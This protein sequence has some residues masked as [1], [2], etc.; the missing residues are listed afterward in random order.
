MAAILAAIVVLG[1][2]AAAAADEPAVRSVALDDRPRHWVGNTC[3]V[4][5]VALIVASFQIHER[6]N[7]HFDDYLEATDPDEI[8][9]HYDQTV[10]LDRWS[11][12][13]LI[14]GQVMIAGGL[15][16]RFLRRPSTARVAMSLG[17]DRCAVSYRF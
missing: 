7:R 9:R 12:G 8:A 1:A 11:S 4:A 5:G 3:V 16:L 17:P 2:R 10:A 13:T 6:A 15:Y 14:G